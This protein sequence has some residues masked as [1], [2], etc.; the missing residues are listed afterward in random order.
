MSRERLFKLPEIDVDGFK[1]RRLKGS[2][3]ETL[4]RAFEER[5]KSGDYGGLDRKLVAMCLV[6]PVASEEELKDADGTVLARLFDAAM[7][8]NGLSP[9]GADDAAKN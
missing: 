9:K 8:H 6:D 4:L 3:R 5:K 1:L 7:D 2:E